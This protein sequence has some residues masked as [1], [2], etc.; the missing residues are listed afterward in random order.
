MRKNLFNTWLNAVLTV[1]VAWG[2]CAVLRRGVVPLF[3]MDWKVIPANLKLIMAGSYPA[4][5]LW[6]PWLCLCYVSLFGGASFGAGYKRFPAVLGAILAFEAALALLGFSAAARIFLAANVALALAG[7]FAIRA[8]APRARIAII[9]AG[10]ILLLP[11]AFAMIKGSGGPGSLLPA[12]ETNRW[13]GLLLSLVISLTSI[14]FSF[15]IGLLLALGRRSKLG[16]LRGACTVFIEVVRGV[17]LITVLFIGYLIIPLALPTG[18]NPTVFIRAMIGFIAFHSAYLAENFRGGLQGIPRTQYEA[19]TSLN[20]GKGQTMVL[21]VLP[22]VLKR[23]IPVLVSSFTGMLKD[24]SLISIIGLLDLI[25]ISTAIA[26][27]PDYM[28]ANTQVLLFMALVY[29]VLCYS[30]SGASS[31]LEKSLGITTKQAAKL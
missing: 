14:A 5:E 21:V 9:A 22:Q 15:P 17:P 20:L 25:G 16:L 12:V 2:A 23:M 26:S 10:W 18:A 11:F 28:M 6:R 8:F 4:S 7:F 30:I 31:K 24:T 13:G 1:L 27:N 29:F 3:S 19:A